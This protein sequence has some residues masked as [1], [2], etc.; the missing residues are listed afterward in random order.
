MLA[1]LIAPGNDAAVTWNV[2][3]GSYRTWYSTTFWVPWSTIPFTHYRVV[4][5]GNSNQAGQTISIDFCTVD[6]TFNPA[7]SPGP[8]L[9]V[10][11]S[12]DRRTSGWQSIDNIPAADGYAGLM[13][14]GSNGTVDLFANLLQL[15]LTII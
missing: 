15:E 11:N 9:S 2:N 3:T 8:A 13:M 14:K 5:A 4:C 1:N 6:G 7:H 10:P 12:Y